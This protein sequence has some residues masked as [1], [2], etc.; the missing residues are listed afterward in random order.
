[1]KTPNS[2]AFNTIFTLVVAAAIVFSIV[3]NQCGTGKGRQSLATLHWADLLPTPADSTAVVEHMAYTLEYAEDYEQARWVAYLLTR[4]YVEG[5]V[6]RSNDFREDPAVPTTS[7]QLED[8]RRSGYSRGHLCPAGDMKWDAQAMS[9][10][11]LLS[12]MSPQTSSFNDGIWKKMEEKVR[13]WATT[14]DSV[15]VVTGPVLRPGLPTIGDSKVAVPEYYY[16]VAY[17]PRRGEAICFLA[18]HQGSKKSIRHFVVSI[19]S[20]ER[21]TGIDFFPALPDS[22]ENYIERESRIDKWICSK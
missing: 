20:V 3:G 17:D 22:V 4:S 10:S 8:Y 15:F 14:Y 1:M 6:P 21:L 16:K 11:F 18:P 13:F 5:E 9:E 7:A 12:N 2:K 19:D